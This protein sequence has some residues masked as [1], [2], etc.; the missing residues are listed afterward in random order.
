MAHD[1]A[2]LPLTAATPTKAEGQLLDMAA[3]IG[4][5]LCRAAYWHEDRCN[6]VGRNVR[7]IVAPGAPIV[8]LVTALGPELYG[9]TAGI[10]LFLAT[11]SGQIDAPNLDRTARGAIRQAL[12]SAPLVPSKLAASFHSGWIGIAYAAASIGQLLDEPELV[13][14][15]LALAQK[16][17]VTDRGAALDVIGGNA[18]SIAPLLWLAGLPGGAALQGFATDL[19]EELARAAIRNSDGWSWDPELASGAGMGH[20]PLCGL[21][22]GASGMGLALMEIGVRLDRR[23]WIDGGLSA[24]AYEDGLFDAGRRNWPDLREYPEL[25]EERPAPSRSF[26]IAW[27]HGAAGIGLARLRAY[28]LLPQHREALLPRIRDAIH[29]T[30]DHLATFPGRA[31]ASPCHGRAGLTELLVAA[32]CTLDEPHW[33]DIARESWASLAR[34]RAIADWPCGVASGRNTPALMLG[35][36]G[37][38]YG[39]LRAAAPE[40]TRSILLVDP[41]DGPATSLAHKVG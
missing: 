12:Q 6:W 32:G 22:H 31:D 21:A 7:E 14:E 19:A 24:F 40:L 4:R 3:R 34:R 33:L 38:G 2:H 41:A 16:T 18:G 35:Y 8:P 28:T 10:A 36:A 13:T 26:M 1:E 17:M 9:G 20:V 15:A 39:L 29:A 37:I 27:C 30:R 5:A 23:D 11:L 25:R